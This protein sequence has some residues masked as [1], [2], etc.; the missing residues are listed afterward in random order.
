M[1]YTADDHNYDD[2]NNI[3]ERPGCEI[4][5]S[6]TYIYVGAHPYYCVDIYIPTNELMPW[7]E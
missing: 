6:G 1:Q 7:I 4:F 2:N 3:H 5:F